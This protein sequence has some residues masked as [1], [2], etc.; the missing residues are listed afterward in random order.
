MTCCNCHCCKLKVDFDRILRA[1]D[2][3]IRG[4]DN[5]KLEL[6][7]SNGDID[8]CRFAQHSELQ[9]MIKDPKVP[10][11]VKAKILMWIAEQGKKPGSVKDKTWKDT[12]NYC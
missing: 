8:C 7:S 2:F 5:L 3:G 4:V 1:Y 9:E 6:S 11:A 12:E 10:A